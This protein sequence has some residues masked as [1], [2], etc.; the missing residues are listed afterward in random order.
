LNELI[1]NWKEK[2][3]SNAALSLDAS[4]YSSVFPQAPI[5]VEAKD[6]YFVFLTE[7][8][9]VRLPTPPQMHNKGNYIVSL[10]NVVKW[11]GKEVRILISTKC[12]PQFIQH[13]QSNISP[14][15]M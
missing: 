3:V 6:D 15:L 4:L 8:H 9:H 7:K 1:P 2:N 5:T 11:L 12:R 13:H 14:V 10:S